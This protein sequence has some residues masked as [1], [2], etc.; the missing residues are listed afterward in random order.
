MTAW[1]AAG[2]DSL[3]LRQQRPW[4]TRESRGYGRFARSRSR[5]APTI[6]RKAASSPLAVLRITQGI[7]STARAFAL[8]SRPSRAA[9]ATKTTLRSH[10]QPE[11]SLPWAATRNSAFALCVSTCTP[12]MTMTPALVSATGAIPVAGQDR[13]GLAW[14]VRERQ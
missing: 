2:I 3:P 1:A 14:V 12:L 4:V 7:L 6:A 13:A 8:A 11:S 9:S 10:I 5:A